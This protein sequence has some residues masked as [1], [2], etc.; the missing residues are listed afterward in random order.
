M[1]VYPNLYLML[2][3]LLEQGFVLKDDPVRTQ[4]FGSQ[5]VCLWLCEVLITGFSTVQQ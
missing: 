3:L 4:G 1:R 2:P 5:G